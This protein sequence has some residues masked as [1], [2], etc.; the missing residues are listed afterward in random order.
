MLSMRRSESGTRKRGASKYYQLVFS[1]AFFLNSLLAGVTPVVKVKVWSAY[2]GPAVVVTHPYPLIPIIPEVTRQAQVAS[3]FE[4][5]PRVIIL[6]PR[7]LHS[8]QRHRR[9]NSK[10]PKCGRRSLNQTRGSQSALTFIRTF[11]SERRLLPLLVHN[12]STYRMNV[13]TS[14][15]SPAIHT[16][17]RNPLLALRINLSQRG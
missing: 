7:Y 8:R 6:L 11:S 3:A 10:S 14:Q 5:N 1:G 13:T 16:A 2:T 17:I 9:R 12:R 15:I 4:P